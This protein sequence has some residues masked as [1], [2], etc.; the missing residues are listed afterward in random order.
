QASADGGTSQ[1]P[2]LF[3]LSGVPRRPTTVEE[4][5]KA[6]LDEIERVKTEPVAE[7]ELQR[8]RNQLDADLVRSLE[9]NS[10]IASQLLEYQALTGDWHYMYKEVAQLK[11]VTPADLTRV[12]KRYLTPEN[13]TVATLVRPS[14][15]PAGEGQ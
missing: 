1:F 9:S 13:R 8:L 2:N 4:L 11:A 3:G 14:Q 5:E 6:V 15:P 7:R 10:G 12:A